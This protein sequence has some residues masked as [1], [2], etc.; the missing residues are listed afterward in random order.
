[1]AGS[2]ADR[3]YRGFFIE[4]DVFCRKNPV[5]LFLKQKKDLVNVGHGDVGY[6]VNI[7]TFFASPKMGPFF[8]GLVKV[9]SYSLKHR[10]HTN[11]ANWT[12]EF[13]DQD[14]Y[15][16][17][18]PI[19]KQNLDD[20]VDG[21]QFEY[22]LLDDV[23]RKHDLLKHCQN[24]RNFSHAMMPHH[25]MSNHDPPTIF[26][27]THCIHPLSY[28]PFTPLAFKMGTAKF[29]GFDPKP[30]GPDERLLKLHAGDLELNNC[31]N[32]VSGEVKRLSEHYAYNVIGML[33]SVI[34]EIAQITNRTLVLPQY[35][36]SKESWAIPMHAILDVRTLGIPY[37]SM[38]REQAF[39]LPEDE[40][41][42]VYAAHN[43]SE[44]FRRASDRKY[45]DV[46]VLSII[47][48]CNIRDYKLPVLET[49]RKTLGWCFD[50]DLEW[51]RAVGAWMD[52][53]QSF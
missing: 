23:D 29:F 30:I 4:M 3:G 6:F 17:C 1:V 35:I 15:K 44:T 11:Q 45:N 19:T 5:P 40:T 21:F 13:F 43:F 26:D 24:F 14:V 50:R 53:C 52:F 8:R 7:G 39:A 33:I 34:I 49:R 9:L 37:R 36:R 28:K 2:I 48:I 27:S 51:S 41:V 10:K 47:K 38:T 42:E 16:Y 12:V 22:Y 32:R 31:W 20:D 18:L 25:V 46:K